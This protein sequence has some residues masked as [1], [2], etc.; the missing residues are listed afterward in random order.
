MCLIAHDIFY[1]FLP[2]FIIETSLCGNE[3]LQTYTYI[4]KLRFDGVKRKK[5][6]T[7]VIIC[8]LKVKIAKF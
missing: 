3:R 4:V 8:N 2:G 6:I 5:S 1:F 7:D